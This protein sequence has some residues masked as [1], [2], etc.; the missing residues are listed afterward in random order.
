MK[1]ILGLDLGTTSIG[2]AYINESANDSS[3]SFHDI[4]R[5]ARNKVAAVIE[6]TINVVV[7]IPTSS[8]QRIEGFIV[9]DSLLKAGIQIHDAYEASVANLV[10]PASAGGNGYIRLR[11]CYV[12]Q[13]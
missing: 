8:R 2:W 6:N 3:N 9:M 4:A 7:A 10:V 11:H 1:K 13:S 12:R 5:I